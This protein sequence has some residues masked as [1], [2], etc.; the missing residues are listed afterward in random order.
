MK[1][2]LGLDLIYVISVSD[3]IMHLFENQENT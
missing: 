3:T 1:I 2:V